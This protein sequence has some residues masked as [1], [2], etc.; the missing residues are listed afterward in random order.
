MSRRLNPVDIALVAGLGVAAVAVAVGSIW[1]AFAWGKAER[2][3]AREAAEIR[4]KMRLNEAQMAP[5]APGS[6]SGENLLEREVTAAVASLARIEGDQTISADERRIRLTSAYAAFDGYLKFK[7]N[8]GPTLYRRGRCAD[9]LGN[10]PQALD[11]YRLAIEHEPSLTKDL[12]PRIVELR[13]VL[14]K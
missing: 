3:A 14:G 7:P 10:L 8:H 11:D 9:L 13:G 6:S 5:D 1:L 4:S 2:Q 12:A